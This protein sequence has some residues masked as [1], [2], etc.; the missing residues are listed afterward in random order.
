M[1]H[2]IPDPSAQSN[3]PYGY[4]HCGCGQLAPIAKLTNS[5]RGHIKG[6][7]VRFLPSHHR[8]SAY[9]RLQMTD[10]VDSRFWAKVHRLGPDECWEW[11]AA[12]DRKGYGSFWDGDSYIAAHRYSFELFYAVKLGD[13]LCCHECDNPRCVNPSH[14]FAGTYADN[15]RDARNKDRRYQPDVSGAN[16]GRAKLTHATVEEIRRRFAA[17]ETRTILAREF[18][19][20]WTTVDYAIKGTSWK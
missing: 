4:C 12:A 10:S 15:N 5:K 14:L 19:V 17:G 16:N 2:S 6:Q 18:G 11:Q 3:I 7:P 9:V 20:S 13:Y 8:R 1:S